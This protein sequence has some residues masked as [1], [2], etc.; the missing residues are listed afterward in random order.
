MHQMMEDSISAPIHATSPNC[1]N[2][3]ASEGAYGFT[4]LLSLVR[5][6]GSAGQTLTHTKV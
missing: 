1:H 6:P 3:H 4:D 2:G 5:K